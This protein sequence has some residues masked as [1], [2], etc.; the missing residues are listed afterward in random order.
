MQ[1][2]KFEVSNMRFGWSI[3][4]KLD[5][6]VNNVKTREHFIS[7][8]Y[9]LIGSHFSVGRS[10]Q[11]GWQ[12]YRCY[13]M[14]WFDLIWSN[15][16]TSICRNYSFSTSFTLNHIRIFEKKKSCNTSCCFWKQKRRPQKCAVMRPHFCVR[17]HVI[18]LLILF[19]PMCV[20]KIFFFWQ[21]SHNHYTYIFSLFFLIFLCLIWIQP[22]NHCIVFIN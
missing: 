9:K 5:S 16:Q 20:W 14:I 4:W 2:M 6:S 1:K 13:E 12:F 8:Q 21:L 11:F 17:L 15:R 22:K 19:Y 3:S 10:V 18:V 7:V